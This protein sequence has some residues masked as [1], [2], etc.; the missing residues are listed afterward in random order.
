LIDYAELQAYPIIPCNLCGSQ[1]NLQRQVIKEMLNNWQR[2]YPGRIETLFKALSD[3]APS[4]L[5]DR[6][7]FDFTHLEQKQLRQLDVQ[8]LP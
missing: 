3:I 6:D 2:H 7:L 8:Q 5:L 4:Q 1:D